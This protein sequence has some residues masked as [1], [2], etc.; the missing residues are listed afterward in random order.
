MMKI[1]PLYA[2]VL[3]LLFIGL[4]IKVIRLRQTLRVGIG[5]AKNEELLRASR[6]HSNFSEYVPLSLI[7][8]FFIETQNAH[9]LIV[10]GLCLMLLVGRS[11]HAYGVS[12][13]QEKLQFRVTGM[14]M[15]FTVIALSAAYILL[16]PVF[17]Y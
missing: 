12:Q 9:A 5:Y 16:A 8:L 10:H 17:G 3:S 4:S 1:V 6:V 14:L 13:V 11:V 7:L 2:A 15:T